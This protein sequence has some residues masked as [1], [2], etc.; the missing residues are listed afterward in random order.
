[1]VDLRLASY[2]GRSVPGDVD[3]NLDTVHRVIADAAAQR[4]DFLCFPE[5]FLNGYG[6]RAT[7]ERGAIP[8]DDPRLD[9]LAKAAARHNLVLLVG[10][11]ELLREPT[12]TSPATHAAPHIAN[13]VLILDGAD[14]DRRLGIYR[15]TMLTGGDFRDMRF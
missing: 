8:P 2:Q 10:F 15:K 1:M 12:P 3:A 11:S 6:D 5:T 9:S 4:A 13:S 14:G 7:I